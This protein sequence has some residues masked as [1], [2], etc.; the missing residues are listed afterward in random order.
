MLSVFPVLTRVYFRHFL[1]EK[2]LDVNILV[3]LL[4]PV[5]LSAISILIVVVYVN[6]QVTCLLLFGTL[7]CDYVASVHEAKGR[8]SVVDTYSILSLKA[9]F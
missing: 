8:M 1:F 5:D 7:L 4:F 2:M 3:M 6:A 9:I